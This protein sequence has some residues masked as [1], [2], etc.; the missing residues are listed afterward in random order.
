MRHKIS[1]ASFLILIFGF[2]HLKAQ[3]PDDFFNA[4]KQTDYKLMQDYMADNI[5]L[6]IIDDV[7]FNSKSQAISRIKNILNNNQIV[8]LSPI[9]VGAA[10]ESK[11]TYKVAKLVTSKASYRLF[12]Y[13]E[14]TG[15]NWKV[16][17]VRFDKA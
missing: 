7:Q 10:K 12:V 14:K 2:I 9:H 15:S 8:S 4:I 11:S 1:L 13:S 3:S 16:V 6:C 17:E 5:N